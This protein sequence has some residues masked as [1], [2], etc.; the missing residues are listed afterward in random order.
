MVNEQNDHPE[1]PRKS[2]LPIKSLSL[3]LMAQLSRPVQRLTTRAGSQH[4]ILIG[5]RRERSKVVV[6]G[7]RVAVRPS[8]RHE[9]L[10]D[11]IRGVV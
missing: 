10:A 7:L 11:S 8:D 3:V 5:P 9:V 2:T 1:V 4:I 6:P